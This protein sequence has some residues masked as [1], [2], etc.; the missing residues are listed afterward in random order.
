MIGGL[1]RH[2]LPHLSRIPHLGPLSWL[3]HTQCCNVCTLE[4]RELL[5]PDVNK[6]RTPLEEATGCGHISGT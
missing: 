1:T 6:G 5:S 2:M 4:Q 3:V